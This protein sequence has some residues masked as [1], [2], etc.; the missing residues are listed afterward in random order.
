M[1]KLSLKREY[2]Y[3]NHCNWSTY[4]PYLGYK[5][6]LS[7]FTLYSVYHGLNQVTHNGNVVV[8]IGV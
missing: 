6:E 4:T 7:N 2:V 8:H 1:S 5:I 3:V